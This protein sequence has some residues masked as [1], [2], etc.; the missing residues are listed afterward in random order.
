MLQACPDNWPVQCSVCLIRLFFLKDFFFVCPGGLVWVLTP[1][2]LQFF[3]RMAANE[4]VDGASSQ[5]LVCTDQAKKK[6]VCTDE[7]KNPNGACLYA[8][9]TMM[10]ADR[11]HHPCP[12]V[13]DRFYVVCCT[14]LLVGIWLLSFSLFHR[15]LS[16]WP[17]HSLLKSLL[18][19][20]G[21]LHFRREAQKSCSVHNDHPSYAVERWTRGR[22]ACDLRRESRLWQSAQC[23]H[24][25]VEPLLPALLLIVQW[26]KAGEFL[27]DTGAVLCDSL[28]FM[29]VI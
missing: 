15:F 27:L 26:H 21:R 28:R 23:T 6:K 24:W 17:V 2:R 7:A 29:C 14:L 9:W 25:L 13:G 3:V 1:A 10:Y 12:Y 5:Y 20:A 19:H 16:P 4:F 11:P 8:V 18:F 22:R